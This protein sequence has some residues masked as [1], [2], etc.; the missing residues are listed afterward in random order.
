MLGSVTWRGRAQSWWPV[1]AL[2]SSAVALFGGWDAAAK[3]PGA[4]YC[5]K[6][7]CHRVMTLP[8]TALAVGRIEIVQ[9]TYYG[10]PEHD[11]YNPRLE[12]SSG[13]LFDPEKADN[14][15]S[16]VYPDGTRL[17]IWNPVTGTAAI[18]R[19]NNAGPYMGERL[20]DVSQMLAEK[21]GF[22]K[23]GVATLQVVV[24]KAPT[25]EEARFKLGRR[26]EA[27]PG[28][29]GKFQNI[30]MATRAAPYPV[31]R[32]NLRPAAPAVVARPQVAG[33]STTVVHVAASGGVPVV[34]GRVSVVAAPV[35]AAPIAALPSPPMALG[36]Q[37]LGSRSGPAKPCEQIGWC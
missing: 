9:A 7:I 6:A 20:L 32:V 27:V 18:A 2:L 34:P 22:L 15:A 13:E 10:A 5:Y 29:I 28:I 1:V 21:L 14:V 23:R 17:L 12:T 31:A 16:P 33:W 26:Y 36:V 3:T 19:V 37:V 8:E 35:L 24:L 25:D 11:P 4:T 30:A